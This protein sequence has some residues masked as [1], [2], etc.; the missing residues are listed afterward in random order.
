[1]V[2]QTQFDII[3]QL[4]G[5]NIKI[6]DDRTREVKCYCPKHEEQHPSFFFN[7]D[8]QLYHCFSCEL[9]GQG[10]NRLREDVTGLKTD[11]SVLQTICSTI[12]KASKKVIPSVPMLP[13][14]IANPGEIY[15]KTRGFSTS[16]IKTWNL[17]YWP[18][19][20][21][22]VIPIDGVGFNLRFIHPKDKKDKYKYIPG[23]RVGDTLFGIDKIE[24][25]ESKS[26]IIVEGCFDVIWMWQC[27]FKNALAILHGDI[28]PKQLKLLKGVAVVI[29]D[30]LDNDL[31]GENITNKIDKTLKENF[32]VKYVKL[33]SGK[34]PND[35]SPELL[36]EAIDRAI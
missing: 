4:K 30:C 17:M 34:D 32:I 35:T 2:T 13:L 31:G 33:P 20:D 6:V 14:A 5:L 19:K 1:M 15:L 36:K 25:V 16:T 3:N 28:T 18:E 26:V 11:P 8:T 27:G 7:L 29:Y 21:G 22:I 24:E 23:T 12:P 9:R 10:I